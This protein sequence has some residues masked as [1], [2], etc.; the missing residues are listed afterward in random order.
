MKILLEYSGVLLLAFVIL[1]AACIALPRLTAMPA[2]SPGEIIGLGLGLVVI[3]GGFM[4][5]YF[6]SSHQ[7]G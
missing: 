2:P 5:Y 1:V 3:A 7:G 6:A 4:W